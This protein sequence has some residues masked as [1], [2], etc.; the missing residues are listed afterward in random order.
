MQRRAFV[1]LAVAALA[2]GSAA[3]SD[4]D[5]PAASD[6]TT[7]SAAAVT[8]TTTTQPAGPPTTPEAAAK[9]LFDAWKR[10]DRDGASRFAK[11]G[12]ISELFAHPNTG[13]TPYDDQ[14]CSPQ[15][16]QFICAWTYPGGALQMTVE[17]WPGG[18]FVVDDITYTAD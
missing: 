11:P 16:G 17:S 15:G 12:P 5:D 9:G 2:T 6:T 3:C 10:G 1:I 13:D 8:T 4:D 18:G 7:T 14:G